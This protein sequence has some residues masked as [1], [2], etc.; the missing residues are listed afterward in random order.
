MTHAI[1]NLNYLAVIVTSIV[2]FLIGWMWYSP[3]LFAKSW[4]AENKFTEE[5]MKASAEKGMAKTMITAFVF[6]IVM[7]WA[8]AA[9]IAAH[10]SDGWLAGAKF[11]AFV[12]F[13]LLAASAAVCYQF[14]QRSWKLWAINSGHNV[15]M[16]AVAGAILGVWR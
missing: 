5:S 14:E 1:M 10:G 8:L 7:T 3:M 12:G 6:T 2:G 11:G 4:M 9:L 13:G 16:C 15:V